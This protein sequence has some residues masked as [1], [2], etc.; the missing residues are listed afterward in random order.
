MFINLKQKEEEIEAK[1]KELETNVQDLLHNK[2]TDPEKEIIYKYI[3]FLKAQISHLKCDVRNNE[4]YKERYSREMN[5][6]FEKEKQ[7]QDLQ[8]K[9]HKL[10]EK[11]A[12]IEV[13][14]D[15]TKEKYSV[16]KKV[17]KEEGK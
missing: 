3:R 16:I 15:I 7:L 2:L 5:E 6:R 1:D 4:G 12:N 11:Q 10:V 14:L 9:Y 8:N 17:F 13:E